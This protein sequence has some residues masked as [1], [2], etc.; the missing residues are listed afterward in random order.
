MDFQNLNGYISKA[1]LEKCWF[2]ML[3]PTHPKQALPPKKYCISE[4][5]FTFSPI[6]LTNSSLKSLLKKGYIDCF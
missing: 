5:F 6:L 1:D 2:A 3:L 4:I